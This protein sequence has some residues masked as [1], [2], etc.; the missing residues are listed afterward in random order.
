MN[1]GVIFILAVLLAIPARAIYVQNDELKNVTKRA[2]V[3]PAEWTESGIWSSLLE[4]YT[5]SIK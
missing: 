5:L 1:L 4:D 3:S 2:N